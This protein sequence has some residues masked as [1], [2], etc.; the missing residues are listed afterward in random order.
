M[1]EKKELNRQLLSWIFDIIKDMIESTIDD[2]PEKVKTIIAVNDFINQ[3]DFD[4]EDIQLSELVG[5]QITN[6]IF[7]EI[8]SNI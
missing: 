5:E 2:S 8:K 7:N 6:K 3:L 1:K 4:L